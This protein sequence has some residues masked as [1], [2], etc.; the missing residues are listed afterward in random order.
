ML[1]LLVTLLGRLR[2][3]TAAGNWVVGCVSKKNS[4]C[5]SA[6]FRQICMFTMHKVHYCNNCIPLS[7]LISMIMWTYVKE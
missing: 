2:P 3:D 5:V 1:A 6:G 4:T 7:C